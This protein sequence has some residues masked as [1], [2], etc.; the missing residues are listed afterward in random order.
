MTTLH[1]RRDALRSAV[2]AYPSVAGL[3]VDAD[4]PHGLTIEVTEHRAV[5]A[6]DV[7][8]R[9]VP[10]TGGGIVLTGVQADSDL[11]SIRRETIPGE[12]VD[13]PRTR[14]ALAV[15]AAAPDELLERSQ[16]LRWSPDGLTL[17]LRDGPPLVFGTREHA[18]AKWAAAARVL[19]D[20]E[21]AG[22]AYLDLRVPGRVAAGG[23]APVP[24][25]EPSDVTQP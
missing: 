24:P 22:A 17:D 23:L 16:R 6:L 1:V 7:D 4:F 10:V 20:P 15:A 9:R 12:R 2:A 5:A 21:A 3:R 18:A 19:A 13:D 8:G 11:P 25:E 14:T